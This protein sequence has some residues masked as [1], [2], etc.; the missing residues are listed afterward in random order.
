MLIQV[1][2]NPI[3]TPCSTRCHTELAGKRN[4][5]PVGHDCCFRIFAYVE[6]LLLHATWHGMA[7][8]LQH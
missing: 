5:L 8:V 1:L 3:A 4:T 7:G 6:G 2:Q